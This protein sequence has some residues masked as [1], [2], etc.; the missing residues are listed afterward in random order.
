M[1][2]SQ[3]KQCVRLKEEKEATR[4]GGGRKPVAPRV[5]VPPEARGTTTQVPPLL[6]LHVP[7]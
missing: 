4:R 7:W 1:P 2:R 5:A 6:Q 3:T